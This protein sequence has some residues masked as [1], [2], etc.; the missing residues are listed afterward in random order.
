MGFGFVLGYMVTLMLDL[1]G[2]L[3]RERRAEYTWK[4]WKCDPGTDGCEPGVTAVSPAR[5]AILISC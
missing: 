1:Q 4:S 3:G 2:P 5:A